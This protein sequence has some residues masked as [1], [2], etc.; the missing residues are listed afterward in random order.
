MPSPTPLLVGDLMQKNAKTY[1]RRVAAWMG[2]DSLTFAELDERADR[3]AQALRAQGVGHGDRIVAWADTCLEVLPLFVALAKLGAVFAPL[4][5]RLGTSEAAVIVKMAQPRMLVADADHL[6]GAIEIASELGIE[7]VGSLSAPDR[8]SNVMDL[9]PNQLAPCPE[10]IDEPALAETDPHVIFFTSGSTGA[11]KGVILSH[12]ANYLRTYQGVFLAE[13]ERSVCMF[14]LFHMAAFTLAL[15]AWQT[16]GEIAF[17]EA[18]T[19]EKILEA[20]EARRANRLYCIPAVWNRIL[21]LDAERFDVSSLRF[22]DTGTSATPIELLKTLK[23]R[24]PGC[25]LRVYYGS[26]ETGAGTTLM[27]ADV[28][29]KPGSVGLPSPGV[30]LRIGDG[31]EICLRTHYLMDG[32]FNNPEA[33]REAMQDGW[34]H[35]GDI[36]ALDDEG[37]LFVVGR[38]KELIRTGG[39]AVAPAEVEAVLS[40]HP[41]I[42]ELAVVGIPD[43]QWGEVICAVVV[44]EGDANITLEALQKTSDGAL[45]GFKKP[46]R[47]EIVETLPRTAATGQV[48]RILLIEEIIARGTA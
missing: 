22:I 33:T 9:R 39:E 11:P 48:Q 19:A 47:L 14:P 30:D 24:F 12:R 41:G 26:T 43:P 32:Y 29:S 28:L 38:I 20:V 13:E 17:V 25:V 2:G 16:Q 37:Y 21:E 10:A 7:R 18:A 4:N 23:D 15:S 5:A 46:R 34:Y 40:R 6:Q 31:G 45:A 27:D 35:T 3:L 36:G 44:P 1:P 8:E 42:R